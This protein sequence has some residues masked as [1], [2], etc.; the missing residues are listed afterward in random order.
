MRKLFTLAL[1]VALVLP[2]SAFGQNRT[3]P[4]SSYPIKMDTTGK[5]VTLKWS[6]PVTRYM[7]TGSTL[8]NGCWI[9][10]ETS[11]SSDPDI[12]IEAYGDRPW[13]NSNVLI[14]NLG[15]AGDR[16]VVS[17]SAAPHKTPSSHVEKVCRSLIDAL[18]DTQDRD[19][20]NSALAKK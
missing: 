5:V 1:A 7:L 16:L 9:W 14:I 10:V 3:P 13:R 2:A 18:P 11:S 17:E 4:S 8:E 15:L 20:I 12:R 6:N 19:R